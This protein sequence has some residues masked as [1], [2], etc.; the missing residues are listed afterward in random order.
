MKKLS[1]FHTL[2][3]ISFM[4]QIFASRSISQWQTYQTPVQS[5]FSDVCVVNQNII[6]AS[7]ETV[8]RTTN[9]GVSWII[10]GTGLPAVQ[11]YHIAAID[12]N[13]AWVTGGA[14]SGGQI[15]RTTNG[16]I[17]WVEQTYSQPYWINGI[18]F[19]NANTGVFLR[20]PLNPPSNDTAGFFI[21]RNGG[22]NWYR[23]LNTPRTTAL[24]DHCMSVFDTNFVSFQ[25]DNN[26]Y[27]LTGGLDNPWQSVSID[28]MG[29][30]ST[31]SCFVNSSTG[32]LA[33]GVG[34]KFRLWNST[35]GGQNWSIISRDSSM[36]IYKLQ[37]FANS[38][39]F[40]VSGPY[41]IGVSTNSGNS[42]HYRIT[43]PF[44]DSISLGGMDGFDT[45]SVW[46]AGNKGRLFKY[47]LAYIGINQLS[48]QIPGAFR[49]YQNYPN[50]FNPST[51][52]KFDLPNAGK[53]SFRIYD[54]L[55]K[56]IYEL[57]EYR[58]SG[59]YEI[60]FDASDYSSGVYYYLI[61][62]GEFAQTKKMILLK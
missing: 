45:T 3:L 20:D 11:F 6:W 36:S 37:C 14:F 10:A 48:T 56:E 15:F 4:F 21:T 33:D 40:F 50:P 41:S 38:P 5:R 9:G 61:E 29:V 44:A 55:G 26:F 43:Y 62:C 1:F 16:G 39:L 8:V 52:I 42:W 53:L 24:V 28:S 13:N 58:T 2:V 46:I 7:G 30:Y 60:D 31:S 27:R 34:N 18:H 12:E 32:Y 23:S 25:D 19:F 51:K 49:L 35:N 22:L 47:N 59:V 57:S 17:N 54:I